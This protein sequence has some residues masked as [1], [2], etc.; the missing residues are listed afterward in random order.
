MSITVAFS[1]GAD[2]L[3]LLVLL[4]RA[5]PGRVSAIYVDHNIRSRS[6]LDAERSLNEE[7]AAALGVPLTVLALK[8]GEVEAF[9]RRYATTTEAAARTLRYRLLYEH[10]PGLIVTAHT[11]DDQVETLM[12]RLI[13][14]CSFRSLAGIRSIN[15]RVVRPLLGFRRQD[16]ESVCR[17]NGLVWSDDST[18]ASLFCLRNRIRHMVSSSLSDAAISSLE[19]IAYNVSAFL[20]TLRSVDIRKEGHYMAMSR[21]ELLTAH[22][23]ALEEALLSAH[24]HFT[25]SILTEGQKK[26]MLEAIKDSISF[27]GRH[28]YIK[29]SGDEVRFY[30]RERYF[31]TSLDAPHFPMGITLSASDDPLALRI[32][33]S[34]I[35]GRAVFRFAADYDE[36]ELKEHTSEV[37]SLI[38]S[39]HVPYAI[40][41]EDQ[42]G[43][44]AVFARVFGGRDRLARRFL[45]KGD[46]KTSI[47]LS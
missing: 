12:M 3:A 6:E 32:D 8:E 13:Q 30:P 17:M 43:I 33:P 26:R 41:L 11:A 4:S 34:L 46:A 27:E 16:T 22:P 21:E 5:M 15:G 29:T 47:M 18:N 19:N 39:Y 9:A 25:A 20:D 37:R 38:S 44:I 10:A 24:D 2:S 36:I 1:G 23:V 35:K 14:G 40:V 31:V 28:Y 45:G 42:V 7:N